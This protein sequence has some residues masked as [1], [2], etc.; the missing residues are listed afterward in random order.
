MSKVPVTST[1]SQFIDGFQ[2]PA[3]FN[4]ETFRSALAYKPR[5]DDVFIVTYPKCGTTWAQHILVL[6]FRMGKPLES[7]IELW[8]ASPFL[9]MAGASAAEEMPR[10]NAI[11][12]HLPYHLI[13]KSDKAKYIYLTRNPKDC[14]VSYFHHMRNVPEHEFNGTFDEFFELFIAG[15]VDYGDYFD[16]VLSWYAHRNDPNVLFLTYEEMKKD[17]RSAIFKMASFIDDAAYAEPLRNDPEKLNNIVKFSSFD[18]MK[19]VV[20]KGI[21]EL[22]SMS[23]EEIMN[24]TLPR[25]FKNMFGASPTQKQERDYTKKDDNAHFVRKGIVGGWKNYFSDEQSKRMDKKF[26]EKLKGTDLEVLWKDNM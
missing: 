24:S 7:E 26:A 6:I 23:K 9:A 4:A 1:V 20:N 14:C 8:S 11:K 12:F 3:F 2:I 18:Y 13:P 21:E 15:K 16:H 17:I 19:K 22:R 10:P 25:E 5:D